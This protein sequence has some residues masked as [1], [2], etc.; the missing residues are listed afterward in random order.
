[1]LGLQTAVNG[2]GF[3]PH[4]TNALTM[5]KS[6]TARSPSGVFYLVFNV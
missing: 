1:M 6:V 2:A 3:T 4:V 5:P